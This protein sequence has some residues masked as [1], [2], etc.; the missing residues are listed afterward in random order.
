[1]TV[2]PQPLR[3]PERLLA[4]R[5][6][7]HHL[8]VARG[9]QHPPEP[10]A[11]PLGV[12]HEEDPDR[13][14]ARVARHG[15]PSPARSGLRYTRSRVRCTISK[16]A[17]TL[18]SDSECPRRSKPPSRSFSWKPREHPPAHR[19]VEVDHHVAAE[20]RVDPRHRGERLRAPAGSRARSGP[21]GGSRRPR[22]TC[23]RGAGTSAACARRRP[24]GRRARRRPRRFAASRHRARDV[25]ADDL[26]VPALEAAATPAPGS[27]ERVGLLPGG[28]A[29]R[30]DPQ[31]PHGR[32]RSRERREDLARRT[33]RAAAAPGRSRSRSS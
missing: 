14:R 33:R 18:R 22:P 28:A 27:R 26:D 10:R 15:A 8:G 3:L 7:A 32:E 16:S 1:M 11:N 29:R 12:V 17:V 31:A 5:G 21:C 25:D 20:D 23:R 30:Q 2:R 6:G 24:T 13:R 19:E 4:V 9:L